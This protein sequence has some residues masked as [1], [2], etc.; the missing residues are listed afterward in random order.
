MYHSA[1]RLTQ[2]PSGDARVMF[3]NAAQ[4]QQLSWNT[5]IDYAA[6]LETANPALRHAVEALYDKASWDIAGDL[7]RLAKAPRVAASSHALD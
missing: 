5:D 1:L 4:G 6:F 3:E 2:S 7:E